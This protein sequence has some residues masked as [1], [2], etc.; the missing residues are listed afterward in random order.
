MKSNRWIDISRRVYSRL[1]YLY[2]HEHRLEYGPSMLQVFTDQ[3]RDAYQENG[4]RGVFS[5]WVRTLWDL[6]V[7]ALKEQFSSPHLHCR[8]CSKPFPMRRCP[9]KAWRWC[10]FPGWSFLLPV[11]AACRPGLVLPDGL[12]GRVLPD[13]PGVAGLG[14]EAQIP[15][16]G[17]GAAG[18][19]FQDGLGFRLSHPATEFRF[20]Q[21]SMVLVAQSGKSDIPTT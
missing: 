10:W 14:V 8:G 9:G 2:P 6:G 19:V 5:V 15:C 16:L 1:L 3:M 21:P 4:G 13:H 11:R 17:P 18:L 20:F 12:P 7:S